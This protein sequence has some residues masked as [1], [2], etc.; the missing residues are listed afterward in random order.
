MRRKSTK[1]N[2]EA[3]SDDDFLLSDETDDDEEYQKRDGLGK[4]KR[5]KCELIQ[6]RPKRTKANQNTTN[7]VLNE[8][9]LI[10]NEKEEDD[11][12]LFEEE[13]KES[14]FEFSQVA[15]ASPSKKDAA[16]KFTE[17]DAA[18]TS[19]RRLRPAL[20]DPGYDM[21]L[22]P[23]AISKNGDG[24]YLRRLEGHE[25]WEK[26]IAEIVLLCGEAAWRR[27]HRDGILMKNNQQTINIGP[28]PDAKPLM[29]EYIS[30]R[31]DTDDPIL[32]FELRTI[33]QDWLQGFA[34]YT[35]FTTWTPYF[36]FT[37]RAPAA[38]ITLDDI[39]YHRVANDQ[40]INELESC[41]RAGDYEAE[42]V[43]WP[44]IAEL[45]LLG[46]LGAG[47]LLARIV[48]DTLATDSQYDFIVLQATDQAIPFYEKLGFER[49][50]AV[51]S[52]ESPK[53]GVKHAVEMAQHTDIKN[54]N[55]SIRL[56]NKEEL[57][58]KPPGARLYWARRYARLCLKQVSAFDT[59]SIFSI[60]VSDE[61]APGYSS[62]ISH[63]I[64]LST[65][66]RKMVDST[67][68]IE[69]A[70]AYLCPE[71]R[72]DIDLMIANCLFYNHT[73]SPV[74]AYARRFR[75]KVLSFLDEAKS[76]RPDLYYDT[77]E[78]RIGD[79]LEYEQAA[80]TDTAVLGYVHWTFPDQA[81]EDQYPSYLMAKRLRPYGAS[82]ARAL[83]LA[84]DHAL[85]I[86]K[87]ATEFAIHTVASLPKIS[88]D[89]EQ[90]FKNNVSIPPLQNHQNNIPFTTTTS[91]DEDI[92]LPPLTQSTQADKIAQPPKPI[93]SCWRLPLD[94]GVP[95]LTPN[96]AVPAPPPPLRKRI[97]PR[98]N[99]TPRGSAGF[100]AKIC[101]G[102]GV[103][104][105]GI[106]DTVNE[107]QKAYNAAKA[108]YEHIPSKI[109]T[110][111]YEPTGQSNALRDQLLSRAPNP[112]RSPLPLRAAD[113]SSDP[114]IHADKL[115]QLAIA[116][117]SEAPRNSID[118]LQTKKRQVK[119]YNKVV[120]VKGLPSCY[121]HVFWFVYQ[122][123]PDM[124]WCHLCPMEPFG[125]FGIKSKREGRPRWRLVPEGR[126]REI[127]VPAAR[128]TPVRHQ[129][130]AKT[131]SADREVFDI[132][133]TDAI[134][135]FFP[136]GYDGASSLANKAAAA[137][138]IAQ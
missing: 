53:A 66:R 41:R 38:A 93:P 124:E 4:R 100:T 83:S 13:K 55:S 52:F 121:P 123:V 73:T 87:Q 35:T 19:C 22:V 51:A 122:Y 118:H 131:Q 6:D 116:A 21:E 130:V 44:K 111:S 72:N 113:L 46:G 48:L 81:V 26:L 98:S 74:A 64:D 45:S 2:K 43:V 132:I 128:C 94:I 110:D 39:S 89:M 105:L 1:Q 30:D 76:K 54:Y 126:A 101:H 59:D 11:D 50:G 28:P 80:D 135:R 96:N 7:F 79:I 108:I 95:H 136:S 71:L 125:S 109:I 65:M 78:E 137:A 34:M 25:A 49:V 69:S 16:R 117:D 104:Y 91:M 112:F 14:N 67:E 40:L 106:F 56:P 47:G 133:D 18:M 127:D 23:N 68:P 102:M 24:S 84:A 9:H 15:S 31:V 57:A 8:Q 29:L 90:A 88:E 119:L 17:R 36:R 63:P 129:T 60:P 70:K 12:I 107:A 42:G 85:S 138:G 77:D 62:L 3:S 32:G 120:H 99:V 58:I 37:N 97:V 86:A 61:V 27:M 20:K 33:R 75:D 92:P 5:Q 10:K 115:R 82:A 114:N 103:E 134:A